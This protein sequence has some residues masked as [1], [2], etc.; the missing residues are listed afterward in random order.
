[1]RALNIVPEHEEAAVQSAQDASS[2]VLRAKSPGEAAAGV[3][4]MAQQHGLQKPLATAAGEAAGTWVIVHGG[5][6]LEAA[7]AAAQATR[8]AGGA[9]F[10]IRPL[11][12]HLNATTLVTGTTS[13]VYQA[14]SGAAGAAILAAGGSVEDAAAAAAAAIKEVGGSK[15]D[16]AFAANSIGDSIAE[17]KARVSNVHDLIAAAGTRA[18]GGSPSS[19]VPSL[20]VHVD[21]E[22]IGTTKV[23]VK[24]A[25]RELANVIASTAHVESTDVSITKRTQWE[26]AVILRIAIRVARRRSD[27]DT[28]DA[29]Q[30]QAARVVTALAEPRFKTLILS[31]AKTLLA[32]LTGLRVSTP[33]IKG[34]QSEPVGAAEGG[35]AKLPSE[36]LGAIALGVVIFAVIIGKGIAASEEHRTVAVAKRDRSRADAQYY[37]DGSCD[38]N[39]KMLDLD[40]E[41]DEM[42][43]APPQT[44]AHGTDQL[45]ERVPI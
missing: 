34:L 9:F 44:Q 35:D 25:E 6:A 10:L 28:V 30:K 23:K 8:D 4:K 22:L 19:N 16:A 27:E 43:P 29:V 15:Q 37:A 13:Q 45:T 5:Y 24:S 20:I 18:A 38:E 41:L 3:F 7:K 17:H 31:T 36:A 1:L 11:L 39:G 40:E 26:Q 12:I 14:L 32:G 42:L 2:I 33:H 21:L